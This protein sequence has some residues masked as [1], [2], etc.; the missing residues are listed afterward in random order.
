MKSAHAR[1]RATVR[2]RPTTARIADPRRLDL[3]PLPTRHT[4]TAAAAGDGE[5]TP[6][7][8]LA[9]RWWLA[10]AVVA[11]SVLVVLGL[12]LEVDELG[13]EIARLRV[14]TQALEREQDALRLEL[15]VLAEPARI[16]DRAAREL[17]MHLPRPEQLRTYE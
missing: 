11:A 4:L 10:L 2:H 5:R 7:L 14:D 8:G 15:A 17:G 13:Y 3:H 16:A 12:R 6:R 1:N 9:P